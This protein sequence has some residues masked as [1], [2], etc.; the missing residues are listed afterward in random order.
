M[1]AIEGKKGDIMTK[2]IIRNDFHNTSKNIILKDGI[3]I[4]SAR[5]LREWKQALCC[6]D[7]LCSGSDGLRGHDSITDAEGNWLECEMTQNQRTGAI[8]LI[9]DN[10]QYDTEMS[11]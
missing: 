3:N 4:I 8:E 7:C 10:R 2:A 9:I 5:R 6:S 1:L 11:D